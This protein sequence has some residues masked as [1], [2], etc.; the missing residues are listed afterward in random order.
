MKEI[1]AFITALSGLNSIQNPTP[2]QEELIRWGQNITEDPM[3]W[4]L[5][6]KTINKNLVYI[7]DGKVRIT[8]KGWISL[9]GQPN[10][11]VVNPNIRKMPHG[12]LLSATKN[13]IKEICYRKKNFPAFNDFLT[14]QEV[15]K[16]NNSLDCLDE[17]MSELNAPFTQQLAKQFVEVVEMDKE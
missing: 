9:F 16:L 4:G 6:E 10:T 2:Q 11:K 8:K 15:E 17:T 5:I 13:M 7:H 14:Q 12:D 3:I 1:F